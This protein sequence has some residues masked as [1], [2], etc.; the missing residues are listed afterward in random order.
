MCVQQYRLGLVV[1]PNAGKTTSDPLMFK[2]AIKITPPSQNS[3]CLASAQTKILGAESMRLIQERRGSLHQQDRWRETSQRLG[4]Q[5]LCR[6]SPRLAKAPWASSA[7]VRLY[8][9]GLPKQAALD[10]EPARRLLASLGQDPL[11]MDPY[12]SAFFCRKWFFIDSFYK[13]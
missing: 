2:T 11:P 6:G 1:V 4:N 12:D 9:N 13:R 10:E 3:K 5:H 8:I 7:P